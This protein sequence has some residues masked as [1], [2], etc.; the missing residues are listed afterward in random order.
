MARV[1]ER[2]ESLEVVLYHGR[3]GPT[4]ENLRASDLINVDRFETLLKWEESLGE[5]TIYISISH[6]EGFPTISLV[7]HPGTVAG[8]LVSNGNAP[9]DTIYLGYSWRYAVLSIFGPLGAISPRASYN[10]LQYVQYVPDKIV[11][12]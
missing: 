7:S 1:M 8:W 10:S 9:V 11:Y 3:Q 6:L 12:I 5:T 2:R 4:S